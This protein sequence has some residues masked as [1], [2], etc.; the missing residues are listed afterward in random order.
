VTTQFVVKAYFN[1][2]EETEAALEYITNEIPEVITQDVVM[3]TPVGGVQTL[4]N[5]NMF[6][7]IETSPY[8]GK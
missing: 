2:T 8:T 6:T 4:L 1:G 5:T 7:R 3:F